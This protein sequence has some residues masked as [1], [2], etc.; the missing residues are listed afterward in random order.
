MGASHVSSIVRP[1]EAYHPL[2]WTVELVWLVRAK[3]HDFDPSHSALSY[4]ALF[5][6]LG[7]KVYVSLD[8]SVMCLAP[9]VT[10]FRVPSPR[11]KPSL[12]PPLIYSPLHQLLPSKLEPPSKTHHIFRVDLSPNFTKP[13]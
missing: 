13:R 4:M 9:N 8:T 12:S 11:V 6:V 3:H 1:K 5:I 10:T 2:G 7:Y